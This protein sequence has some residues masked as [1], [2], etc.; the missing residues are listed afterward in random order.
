M[1]KIHGQTYTVDKILNIPDK[2]LSNI[3][4]AGLTIIINKCKL[5]N[6]D[7]KSINKLIGRYKR[8]N[9]NN[10][11]M[12]T[13]YYPNNRIYKYKNNIIANLN[14]NKPDFNKRLRDLIKK[15]KF[16]LDETD[17]IKI[18]KE[19]LFSIIQPT[20]LRNINTYNFDNL[21]ANLDDL[22]EPGQ[23]IP[24]TNYEIFI[25]SMIMTLNNLIY[26]NINYKQII[27]H[28]Y[29]NSLDRVLNLYPKN[30]FKLK[31]ADVMDKFKNHVTIMPLYS[32]ENQ[33]NNYISFLNIGFGN[34]YFKYMDILTNEYNVPVTT[35]KI[36]LPM[37]VYICVS[38]II[39]RYEHYNEN[40]HMEIKY[41]CQHAIDIYSKMYSPRIVKK[42]N[43][44]EIT[45]TVN[46]VLCNSLTI[47]LY[48]NNKRKYVFFRGIEIYGEIIGFL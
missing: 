31:Y 13:V 1:I 37:M 10:I 3:S 5:E 22:N 14:L 43:L 21:M 19:A 45:Q 7:N 42:Y 15:E 35:I 32:R 20:V 9:K 26:N 23:Y 8:N 29:T 33:M 6:I 25:V 41:N 34:K 39:F 38:K 47:M 12:I 44:Y 46:D 30:V 17:I 28:E 36:D 4:I 48:L 24:C 27:L 16:Y 11:G 18:N 2:I 40:I